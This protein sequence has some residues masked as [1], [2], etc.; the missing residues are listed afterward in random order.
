MCCKFF[1]NITYYL[2]SQS[3]FEEN[4]ELFPLWRRGFI[5]IFNN[6]LEI[7]PVVKHYLDYWQLTIDESMDFSLHITEEDVI[8]VCLRDS[9]EEEYQW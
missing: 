1:E 7:I 2:P 4:K 8:H 3:L 9:H 6:V 5:A